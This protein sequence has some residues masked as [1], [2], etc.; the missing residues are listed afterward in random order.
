[1][2]NGKQKKMSCQSAIWQLINFYIPTL[3]SE[4]SP[5]ILPKY[6]SR[7]AHNLLTQSDFQK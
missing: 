1:M 7:K 5:E 3:P 2:N 4:G 6:L